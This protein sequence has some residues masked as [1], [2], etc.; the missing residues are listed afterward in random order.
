MTRRTIAR[1]VTLE[2]T[3][4]HLGVPV[5]MTFRPAS[6]GQ[7]LSFRRTDLPGSPRIAAHADTAVL[8]ERRTQ[9]GVDPVSVHT[10]EHVL[11]A[12]AGLEIDD[13]SIELNGPEA[14]ILDG[15]A[16]PFFD[17]LI[18]AGVVEQRG[19]PEVLTVRRVV[20]V[21]DGDA[22][23]EA[24]PSE[25]LQLDVTIDFPHPVS[26]GANRGT[27]ASPRI[28]SPPSWWGP[29]PLGSSPRWRCSARAG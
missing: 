23:Y 12:I 6:S 16:G 24:H 5:R 1:D 20:R 17:A 25:G 2:G 3:G 15:S 29:A 4:L 11:A 8:T 21:A 19:K 26:S 9:L 27:S 10:V 22:V 14:P 18:A 28:A 7:G 13:I